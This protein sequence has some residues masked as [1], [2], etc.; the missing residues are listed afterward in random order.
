MFHP[1]IF[2]PRLLAHRRA[3]TATRV[4]GSRLLGAPIEA[5]C[6][7]EVF[8]QGNRVRLERGDERVGSLR[9]E[10][11]ASVGRR[12]ASSSLRARKAFYAFCI[13]SNMPKISVVTSPA[14]TPFRASKLGPAR[15]RDGAIH[16]ERLLAQLAAA[17]DTPIALISASAGYGKSTL[18]AQWTVR[19]QRPVAWI[20]LDAG[21]NDPMV[22][23]DS[24]AYA[25]DRLD[26]AASEFLHEVQRPGTTGRDG[27]PRL[28]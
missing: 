17:A 1:R 2:L 27:H 7:V 9:P 25:L 8:D 11:A 12:C 26:P 21:D 5:R 16:R 4:E 24:V 18:A 20:N 15:V 3:R 14:E 6:M 23:L 13:S 22:F 19:C 10:R 28:S